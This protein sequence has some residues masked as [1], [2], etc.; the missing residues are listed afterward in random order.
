MANEKKQSTEAAVRE[1]RIVLEELRGE[2]KT[3]FP[4]FFETKCAFPLQAETENSFSC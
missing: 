3:T 4:R 2:Q 1:I